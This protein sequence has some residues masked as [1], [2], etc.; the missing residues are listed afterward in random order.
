MHKTSWQTLRFAFVYLNSEPTAY[1]ITPIIASSVYLGWLSILAGGA[2]S[3]LILWFTIRVGMLHP[4]KAWVDFGEVIAGRWAHR[5]FI[6]VLIFWAVTYSAAD[7]QGITL[8]YSGNYMRETPQWF[9]QL[10]LGIVILVTARWGFKTLLYMSDGLFFVII[11]AMVLTTSIFV[12]DIDLH[13][14]AGII[15][16]SNFGSVPKDAVVVVSFFAEWVVFLFLA[17]V[18][19]IDWRMMRNLAAAGILVA[20][21]VTIAWGMTFLNFGPHLGKLLQY[22]MVELVRSSENGMLGNSD[23]L[24]IGLW[25]TSMFIHS[26][27][28]LQVGA[29][30][31]AKLTGIKEMENVFVSLLACCAVVFAYQFALNPTK[32]IMNFN[33]FGVVLFWVFVECIPVYYWIISRFRKK[34]I[35][36]AAQA[37]PSGKE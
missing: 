5:F 17:P 13:Q 20:I 26:A 18:F 9:I 31:L 37:A 19:N 16:H 2:I 29:R 11:L 15:S 6:G 3:L 1:L 22:P 7:I 23:P 30:C 14:L 24:L 35:N 27:F 8:F 32:Y 36:S 10:I 34:T 25:S 21:A 4:S 28:L 33:S 12:Q